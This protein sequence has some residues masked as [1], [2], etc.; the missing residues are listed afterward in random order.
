MVGATLA[1]VFLAPLL[2]GLAARKVRL[3]LILGYVA[4]GIL[5]S[6]FTPAPLS[7]F[8]QANPLQRFSLEHKLSF[9]LTY[10]NFHANM[11]RVLADESAPPAPSGRLH[12]ELYPSACREIL[13]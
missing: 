8:P 12:P 5:I 10:D 11:P 1:Y 9:L 6:P 2:G 4:G 3:P 13:I 7:T